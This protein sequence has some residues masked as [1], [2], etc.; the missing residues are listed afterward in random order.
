MFAVVPSFQNI[1]L[2]NF[3]NKPI[4]RD[5]NDSPTFMHIVA[6]VF[7]YNEKENKFLIQKRSIHKKTYP[8]HFTDS[9]SGHINA[10][11]ELDLNFIKEGMCREL[12]EEMGVQANPSDLNL[13]TIF[14]DNEMNEI[15]FV[16]LG[17]VQDL[18]TKLDPM[19]VSVDGSGWYTLSELSSLIETEKFV[20]PVVGL[21]KVL[22]ENGEKIMEF[23]KTLDEWQEYWRDFCDL[24]EYLDWKVTNKRKIPLYIGRFQPFHLGHLKCLELIRESHEEI[25]I[26]IGSA[27]YSR[28]KRNPLSFNARR[29]IL[30]H[31]LE[32]E[33][34]NFS[35]VFI[36]PIPDMHDEVNWMLNVK[37]IFENDIIL[38]SNNDWVRG[39]AEKEDV[40]LG[41]KFLFDRSNLKAT[42]IRELIRT[43]KEWKQFT[44]KS[45]FN[46]MK[47][48]GLIE[49]IK[50]S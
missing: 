44:P 50:N 40:Q 36:I 47:E 3:E 38:F 10:S 30:K 46:Y 49:K 17:L 9:A 41:E 2:G 18:V 21:W 8:G 22:I 28:S 26:G 16:F 7:I 35:R 12:S 32:K 33:G 1:L 23:I 34:L 6:G 43:G 27:Q 11:S 24:E 5:E 13:W 37:L 48:K 25:I 19:E 4:P 20:P 15:K 31:I 45:C 39:L 29:E 42:R 14:H